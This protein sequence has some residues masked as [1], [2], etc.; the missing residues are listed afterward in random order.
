MRRGERE[1]TARAEIESIIHRSLVCR[2]GL[3]GDGRPYVIPVCFGY[4]DNILYFHSAR[5]GKKLEILREGNDV[6]LE[7]DIDHEMVESESGCKWSMKY[8]SV[9]G[10]GK[11]SII[12][13]PASKQ[14]A[15]DIIMLHYSNKSFS[16]AE[17]AI[18][19]LGFYSSVG[20]IN[21]ALLSF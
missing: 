20:T 2:I 15:Y 13:D 4:K 8:R 6:C 17:A 3:S 5:E 10:Y 16:Y 18:L 14:A 1:I 11:A 9:I 7:F 21:A 12:D 19:K